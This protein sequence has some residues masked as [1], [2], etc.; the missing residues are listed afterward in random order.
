MGQGGL[1]RGSASGESEAPSFPGS[2]LGAARGFFA[3]SASA[4]LLCLHALLSTKS[5]TQRG[6]V[7]EKEM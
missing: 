4:R 3:I 2:C 7:T 6:V 1:R 5:D